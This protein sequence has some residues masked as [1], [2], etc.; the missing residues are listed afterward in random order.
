[1]PLENIWN[2]DET[3]LTDDPGNKKVLCKRGFKYPERIL[4]SSKTSTL[5][6]YC[7]STAGELLPPFVVYKAKSV[8]STWTQGSPRGTRYDATPSGWF[9][10]RTF[11]EWFIELL[12]PRLKKLEGRKAIIGDNLSSHINSDVLRVCW[13]NNIAFHR[14][15]LTC[16]NPWTSPSLVR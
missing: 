13:E 5:L 16:V 2:Y 8:W 14:T 10:T 4:N 15:P 7:G 9:D 1:L 11:E 6:M 12:L 3:N